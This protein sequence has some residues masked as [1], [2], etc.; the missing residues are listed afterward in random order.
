[1]ASGDGL[2]ALVGGLRLLGRLVLVGLPLVGAPAAPASA[3]A[4]AAAPGGGAVVVLVLVL[5]LGLL[6]LVHFGLGGLRRLGALAGAAA[7][8]PRHLC[9]RGRLGLRGGGFPGTPGACPLGVDGHLVRRHEQDTRRGRRPPARPCGR[10]GAVARR[11]TGRRPARAGRIAGRGLVPARPRVGGGRL[12]APAA[13][14]RA[15]PGGCFR[16]GGRT[17]LGRP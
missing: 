4:P 17:G 5:V 1:A 10:L 3:P 11:R 2:V 14:G 9:L 6:D 16:P 8:A 13:P 7:P 12:G 15:A